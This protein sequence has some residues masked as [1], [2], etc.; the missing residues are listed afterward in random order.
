M[1]KI[2]KGQ[3]VDLMRSS[4]KLADYN[5]RK[6]T[7]KAR[8]KLKRA[9]KK[10]GVVQPFIVNKQTGN[11]LVS[12]HQ[13]LNI[14]DEIE[15]YSAEKDYTVRCIVLD[16]PREEEIKLNVILNNA[17]AM[18]EW[19]VDMLASV[20][21][22]FPDIDFIDDLGFERV[23]LDYFFSQSDMTEEVFSDSYKPARAPVEKDAQHFR[24]IKQKIRDEAKRENASGTSH[25]LDKDDYH[26]TIVFNNNEHKAAF[27]RK[28]GRQ[29]KYL[30]YSQ[31]FD[32]LIEEYRV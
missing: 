9:I 19:D 32:L 20:H 18:G 21:V 8:E 3:I 6:I 23:D 15:K 26:L 14:L 27:M 11:T 17:S 10:H 1:S 4:I 5:P 30:S 2:E 24:D 22:D 28:I 7:A 31:V 13:R 25:I 16:M 29:G 12:G